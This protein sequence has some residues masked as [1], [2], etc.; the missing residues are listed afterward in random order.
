MVTLF[1]QSVYDDGFDL[2]MSCREALKKIA[3]REYE[4]LAGQGN[5]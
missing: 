3:R 4:I 2:G 1:S 5:G